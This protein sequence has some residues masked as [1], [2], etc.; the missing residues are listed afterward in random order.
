M[1]CSICGKE[2]REAVEYRCEKCTEKMIGF[3]VEEEG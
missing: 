2:I 3:F 1:N